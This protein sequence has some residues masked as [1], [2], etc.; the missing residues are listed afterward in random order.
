MM[1][2]HR[3]EERDEG[4]EEDE[5][6]GGAPFLRAPGSGTGRPRGGIPALLAVE[7][8]R[9]A[10]RGGEGGV[11]TRSGECI[12]RTGTSPM[13]S[14]SG[15][16]RARARRAASPRV[17]ASERTPARVEM[18][19]HYI[20]AASRDDSARIVASRRRD[21]GAIRT[22]S[23]ARRFARFADENCDA[24]RRKRRREIKS[25]RGV[26]RRGVRRADAGCRPGGGGSGRALARELF[27]HRRQATRSRVST[28]RAVKPKKPRTRLRRARHPPRNSISRSFVV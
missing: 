8:I 21:E 6:E 15:E 10:V 16:G 22:S 14:R 11:G 28:V 20:R 12:P 2:H 13:V 25:R 19:A 18:G 1:V 4:E 27:H 24:S 7:E 17:G 5:G 23:S 9:R 26:R 3:G